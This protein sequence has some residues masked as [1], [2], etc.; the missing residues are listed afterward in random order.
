MLPFGSINSL[1][2]GLSIRD[3]AVS[4]RTVSGQARFRPAGLPRQNRNLWLMSGGPPSNLA[5]MPI[6]VSP[7]FRVFTPLRTV[8]AAPRCDN[9]WFALSSERASMFLRETDP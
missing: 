4:D 2:V 1:P 9:W 3:F 7:R 5:R 6:A 8:A